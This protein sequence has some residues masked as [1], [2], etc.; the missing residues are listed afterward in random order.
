M[1]M[2]MAALATETN[3]FSPMPTGWAGFKEVLY[4]KHASLG[5]PIAFGAPLNVWRRRAQELGWDVA[6]GLAT[7]AQP[8]GPTIK[9]VYETMRDDILGDLRA[10][11]PVDVV[12]MSMH[13]SMIAEGYDDCEGDTL[14]RIRD[15]VGP[16]VVIGVELDPHN[17]LT[18]AMINAADLIINFKEYP[19]TDIE[20]RAEELFTLAADTLS[21]KITPVMRDYDCR[22]ISILQTPQEPMRGFVDRMSEREG[23]NGILSVSLTHGFPWGD[24]DR[25][26]ARALVIADGDAD[27]AARTAQEVGEDL[28]SIRDGL[29]ADWPGAAKGIQIAAAAKDTP[30]VL[31][32][33]ADNAGGGAP[34]DSTYVLHEVLAQGVKDVA[35][36]IFWDPVMV[37]MCVEAG[38][39]AEMKLRIGGKICA[40]SGTPVDLVATVRGIRENHL[41]HLGGTAVPLGT[42]VWVETDG[43]H[44][45]LSEIRSQTFQPEAFTKLGM[46]LTKMQM[47]VVKSSQHFY[48]GFAP[49]AS[50][51]IHMATPGALSADFANIPYTKKADAYWPKV[52]N[53]FADRE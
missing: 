25:T 48:A 5:E 51:V 13:G 33:F 40:E 12:M 3:T 44:L 52:E 42:C 34:S 20:P 38:L 7:F 4:T 21:G 26:G 50:E 2:F 36:G 22:M 1:K 14:M 45:L 39:G 8:A 6:E 17:H 46:D 37:R 15:I 49:I 11:M 9:A 19:H 41:Q 23:K 32:D 29:R 31:A 43:V 18:E 30:V 16:D 35:L 47:V 10:A 28:W 53:P 27:L 24:H